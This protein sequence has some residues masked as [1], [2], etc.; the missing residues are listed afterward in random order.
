ML[1]MRV[2][3][4]MVWRGLKSNNTRGKMTAARHDG[5]F[6]DEAGPPRNHFR[7]QNGI[8]VSLSDRRGTHRIALFLYTLCIGNLWKKVPEQVSRITLIK[9][10]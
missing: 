1:P 8:T 3:F 9:C 7:V 6:Q 5:G 10:T 2:H 4:G